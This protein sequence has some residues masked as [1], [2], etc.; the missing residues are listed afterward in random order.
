MTQQGWTELDPKLKSGP[1]S[2]MEK[3]IQDHYVGQ[4]RAVDCLVKAYEL[5]LSPLREQNKPVVSALFLGPSGVG[6]T[7]LAE[8]CI[9]YLLSTF[10]VNPDKLDPEENDERLITKVECASYVE[11]HQLSRLI[12]APPGYIGYDEIPLLD[13]RKIDKPTIKLAMEALMK[14]NRELRGLQERINE[15]ENQRY[16]S[17]ASGGYDQANKHERTEIDK[18]VAHL[19]NEKLTLLRKLIKRIWSVVLFDEIEKAN[20]SI[21]NFL[22]E[23][24]AEGK[25]SLQNETITSFQD[26]FLIMTS[27]AG[28]RSISNLINDKGVMGFKSSDPEKSQKRIYEV[29]MDELKKI[30]PTEFLGRI[31]QNVIVL[32][33]L[34]PEEIKEV[35]EITLRIIYRKLSKRFPIKLK[36]DDSVKAYLIKESLDHKEY[37]AR[38]VNSKVRR[39]IKEPLA[40]IILS[41]QIKPGDSIMVVKEKVGGKDKIKYFKD[42]YYIL[43]EL[44]ID[45]EDF[46]KGDPESR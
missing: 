7:L 32:H 9:R 14:S 36:I 4:S 38:L 34:T 6:K 40:S 31:E 19:Q 22:L 39:Y 29:A 16:N 37:G 17:L 11:R 10:G 42:E 13:Q 3:F 35:L 28:S 24:T 27:N 20:N 15:M 12:G 46:F 8:M 43:G 44:D 5:T 23:A 1:G 45:I 41:D 33:Y 21:R 2:Q 26:T 30:F 25:V 18:I